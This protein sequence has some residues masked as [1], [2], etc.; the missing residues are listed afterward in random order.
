MMKKIL[1]GVSLL[2]VGLQLLA[3][4]S[5]SLPLFCIEPGTHLYYERVKAGSGKLIQT[6]DM[7]IES[8]EDSLE[9]K[10]MLF[11]TDRPDSQYGYSF[12]LKKGNHKYLIRSSQDY[13]WFAYNI[14]SARLECRACAVGKV[15]ILRGD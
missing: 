12:K 10:L 2:L 4:S 6:T 8:V 5:E 11:E 13:N 14:N 1:L 9:A 3:Q 15:Q 7:D